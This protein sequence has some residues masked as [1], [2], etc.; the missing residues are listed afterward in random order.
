MNVILLSIFGSVAVG[1]GRLT[2]PGHH[3]TGWP[4]AYEALAHIWV[5]MLI[6]LLFFV[7]PRWPI[8]VSLVTITVI[9]II[10]GAASQ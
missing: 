8:V 2:V 7:S 5:G 9:E 6:A 1:L 4:G 10:M 3:L